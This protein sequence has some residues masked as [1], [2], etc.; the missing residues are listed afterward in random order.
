M[1]CVMIR[2]FVVQVS[3]VSNT[4]EALYTNKPWRLLQVTKEAFI[5]FHTENFSQTGSVRLGKTYFRFSL[6]Y[7]E[8][9]RGMKYEKEK[10]SF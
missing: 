7:N 5:C 3:V 4:A 10:E 2:E 8:E 6:T 9:I 1:F